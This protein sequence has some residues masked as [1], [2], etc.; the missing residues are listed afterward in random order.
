MGR[1][2]CIPFIGTCFRARFLFLIVSILLTIVL[3]PLFQG[4]VRLK[5]LMDISISA[6]LVT[7]VYAVS[8]KKH[9]FLIAALLAIPMLASIWLE[10]FLPIPFA[11]NI[12]GSCSGILF[13][14]FIIINIL[15]FIFRERKVTRDLIYAA[16]VVYLLMAVMWAF[17]YALVEALHAGS[18]SVP[19]DKITERRFLFIYYSFVTL[20]T[21]GYGDI[22]PLTGIASSLTILE[23]IIGQIYLVVLVAWLVGMHV[24][25]SMERRSK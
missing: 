6:I 24:S 19:E 21:L 20:T 3:S 7:A 25:Q 15:S 12:S 13:V 18:F 2:F 10:Q 9:D 22:T 1:E 16:I 11:I 23:A 8:H 4:F 14:A 5:L 17:M